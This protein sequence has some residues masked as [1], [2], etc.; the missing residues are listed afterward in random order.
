MERWPHQF[1]NTNREDELM[2]DKND[3]EM[4]AE[5]RG[6]Y[7]DTIP[8]R[9]RFLRWF[10]RGN[11]WLWI[12]PDRTGEPSLSVTWA[13]H[14]GHHARWMRPAYMVDLLPGGDT[15]VKNGLLGV[16]RSY[17]GM[18]PFREGEERSAE[19][20]EK[21]VRARIRETFSLLTAR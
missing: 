16:W 7:G 13:T 12:E 4:V 14:R 21:V 8:S 10:A 11:G 18:H 15:K 5:L 1:T 3:Y 6:K 9:T 19:I 17:V 2:G 20:V